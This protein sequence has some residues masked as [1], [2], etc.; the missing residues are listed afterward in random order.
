[1]A[2]GVH[3]QE[4]YRDFDYIC[5]VLSLVFAGCPELQRVHSL[6]RGPDQDAVRRPCLL[7]PRETIEGLALR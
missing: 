3:T 4:A 6:R 2:S 1:M 5:A 7:Q